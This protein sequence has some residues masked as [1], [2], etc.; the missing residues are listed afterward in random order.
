MKKRP[1]I[2]IILHKNS[3]CSMDVMVS[4]T[5]SSNGKR[6]KSER[7]LRLASIQLVNKSATF[8]FCD[9]LSP[10]VSWARNVCRLSVLL[11][12]VV[13]TVDLEAV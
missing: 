9:G 12:L 11:G 3:I 1:M 7:S 5:S 8:T 6:A 2:T 13:V 4:E 10:K